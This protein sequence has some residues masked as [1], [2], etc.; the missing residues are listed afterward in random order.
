MVTR[1]PKLALGTAQL[2]MAYGVAGRSRPPD[3]AEARDILCLANELGI[4]RL[5]TAAAYGDIE[6]RLK[7]L[8]EDLP[9][10]VIS[11]IPTVP[12]DLDRGAAERFVSDAI[13]RSR[14]RLGGQLV[15][16]LFHDSNS[17]RGSSGMH[18]WRVA[19]EQCQQLGISLGVSGYTP[20][21]VINL[22][23][24]P[25]PSMIQVPGSALDQRLMQAADRLAHCEVT[26]R[27]IFLQGLLLM[28][29]P[30]A[31]ARVPSSRQALKRW[32]AWRQAKGLTPI[33]AAIA[34]ARALPADYCVIGVDNPAQLREIA[35]AWNAATPL[36]APEL[37]E[38]DPSI[39]DPRTWF[40]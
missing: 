22:A 20:Q 36:A 9:F 1:A 5:D 33:N 4:S 8:V 26:A 3:D 28:S 21:D 40:N 18:L 34:V 11:K 2:G 19:T 16:L 17:L 25:P 7:S 10:E 13:V 35:A 15:G 30:A 29:L 6:S 23:L 12:G 24:R 37:A 31:V 39:I 32:D 27:S 38:D 14:D